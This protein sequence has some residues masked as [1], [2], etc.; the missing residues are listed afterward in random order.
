[1]NPL[2][3]I[4]PELA[5]LSNGIPVVFLNEQGAV[6]TIYWWNRVGSADEKPAQAGFSHFLEHMLFKD[7]AAKETG[8][9]STGQM[10]RTIESLGGDINAYTS[11]DQTVYHVTCAARH[12][13]S[14]LDA[15]GEMA[16]PQKFLKSD[17]VTEREV[18]LEELRKNEDSPSRQ[19]FQKLFSLTFPRH[20]Y[21]KPVIGF[22]KTL[23]A[24]KV[25]DLDAFYRERYVSG[26]MGLVLVGPFDEARKKKLL[27][28]LEKRFGKKI[29][30]TRQ[31]KR[32]VRPAESE[33]SRQAAIR[34]QDFDVTSPTFCFSFRIPEINHPDL[35]ALDLLAGVLGMGELSRLHQRLFYGSSVV[36]D[37]ACQ[38]YVPK[39]PGMFYV[40]AELDSMEKIQPAFRECLEEFKRIQQEGPS[41]EELER[42][43]AHAESERLY[44][45]QTVDGLAGR[46]GFM[47][48]ELGDLDFDTR[49]LAALRAVTPEDVQKAAKRYFDPKR[50]SIVF[51]VPRAEKSYQTGWVNAELAAIDGVDHGKP[52]PAPKAEK[53]K[54]SPVGTELE[55]PVERQ[56]LSNGTRLV[57]VVRPHSPVFSMYAL[58]L[59]GLRLEKPE[60]W[61]AANLLGLTW[62]KGTKSKSAR[63][64]ARITEGCAS[65]I[66][67]VSGRNTTGLQLT[68]LARDWEKLTDLFLET[69]AEPSFTDE[70]FE[71]SRRVT[72]DQI[73][74]I[75]DHSA[76]LCSKL[77]LETLFEGHPYGKVSYGDLKSLQ[78]LNPKLLHFYHRGWMRPERLSLSVS[79][80][81]EPK[82]WEKFCKN[83][84]KALPSNPGGGAALE[85]PPRIADESELKAPRWVEKDLGREQVHIL[86]G[87]LGSTLTSKDRYAMRILQTLLGGQSGRLFIELREKKSLAYTVSPLSFEGVERG[88]VGTYIACSR[89][90]REES[91]K[92]IRTVLEKLAG[93]KGPTAGEMK[94]AVE[95][96]WGRRAMDL[97][98]DSSLSTH[99]ALETVYGMPPHSEAEEFKRISSV[100]PKE[101][102]ALCRRLLVEAPQVTCVVG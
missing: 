64:I 18:I 12:W 85:S 30:A 67:G 51:L 28:L 3:S 93:S 74:S 46:L 72:E 55:L 4:T 69:L 78:T 22:V 15:F 19:L 1:M 65:S 79:G 95:Y 89:E 43:L 36:T 41:A 45:G 86:V 35:P 49:Y 42:V 2:H 58:A 62:A 52:V 97:Q 29:I 61:G 57:R 13:E 38:V 7:A 92:G 31:A 66:D 27:A 73:K 33:L 47:K 60:H 16:K 50:M 94:R 23:K 100:T 21:G 14:V 63:E 70:E 25:G 68:G 8:K 39:D 34:V 53:S 84:E 77:F 101:V 44:A 99:F 48:F 91:I 88:Y 5:T 98:G 32:V 20:P 54:K 96:F 11:F 40:Q 59:G 56:R 26:Q 90:K 87:S 37:I 81:I 24:A 83:L 9:S 82:A 80:A 10:A 76:Q 75:E 17:F 102:S 71:H 6:A